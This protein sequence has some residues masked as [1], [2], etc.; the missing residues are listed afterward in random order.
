MNMSLA[1]SDIQNSDIKNETMISEFLNFDTK[2]GHSWL[3][4]ERSNGN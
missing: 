2:G 4:T 3:A 1:L